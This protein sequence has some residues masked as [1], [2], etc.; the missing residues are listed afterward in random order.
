MT[1]K[2]ANEAIDLNHNEQARLFLKRSVRSR[3]LSV[4]IFYRKPNFETGR[5]VKNVQNNPIARG[6]YP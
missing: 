2:R 6:G 5:L 3:K 1:I 4:E